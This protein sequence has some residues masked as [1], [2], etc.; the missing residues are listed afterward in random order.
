MRAKRRLPVGAELM[1]GPEAGVHFRV[2]APAWQQL[3]VVIEAPE[4]REVKLA[5]EQGGYFSGSVGGIGAGA[6]YRY[7]LGDT[8]KL[9]ADPAA[10]FQPE[11]VFGP[12]EVVDPDAF[13]W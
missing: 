2:W 4:R 5:R 10:R 8:D 1:R 11:G 13:A 6:R 7:R 12:S 3:S 9:L